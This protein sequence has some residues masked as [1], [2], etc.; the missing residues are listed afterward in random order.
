MARFD[1]YRNPEG[2]GC[3]LDIQTDLLSHLNSRL[4]VPLLP[5]SIAPQPAKI[6]NP[7]FEAA[8]ETLVMVTQFMAAVPSS[9]LR[10]PMASLKAEHDTIAAAL[11]FLLQGF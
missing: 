1:V 9:M 10:T 8:G 5:L 4:V 7:S 11:D 3:L 2:D 6:L